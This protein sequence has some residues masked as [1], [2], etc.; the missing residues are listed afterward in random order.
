MTNVPNIVQAAR[1][2]IGTPY[3]HQASLKNVGCDCLGLV[4]G[5]WRECCG[6][7]PEPAPPYVPDWAESGGAETLA[8]AAQRHLVPVDGKM[9]QAGDV[10]LFRWRPWLPAKH[11]G[12]ATSANT[13]VHAHDKCSVSEIVMSAWWHRHLAFVFRFPDV[14]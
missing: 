1:G 4:R 8:A 6:D 5:V 10:L 7:E 14:I 13:M 9:F 3:Q 2:W 11:A 12:I